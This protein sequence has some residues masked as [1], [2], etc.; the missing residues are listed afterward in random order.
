M[1]VHWH[2][3]MFVLACQ[4]SAEFGALVGLA[5]ALLLALALSHA[6]VPAE[7]TAGFDSPQLVFWPYG[8]LFTGRSQTSLQQHGSNSH[9][10]TSLGSNGNFS[11]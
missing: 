6:E 1:L 4:C 7:Q 5:Q 3:S 11:H 9:C 2:I 10:A 8:A